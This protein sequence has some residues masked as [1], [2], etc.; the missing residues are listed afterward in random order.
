[1]VLVYRQFDLRET[2]FIIPTYNNKWTR[3]SKN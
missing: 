1:M 3:I 2:N